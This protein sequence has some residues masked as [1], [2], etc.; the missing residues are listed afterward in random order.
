MVDLEAAGDLKEGMRLK[1]LDARLEMRPK[2]A[3]E[4][5]TQSSLVAEI[6]QK[7][8]A[9]P[10][11]ASLAIERLQREKMLVCR[12][13]AL[14]LTSG[15]R[16]LA[17][18]LKGA[19]SLSDPGRAKEV[20]DSLGLLGSGDFEACEGE[21]IIE[22]EAALALKEIRSLEAFD[23]PGDGFWDWR[24]EIPRV[25]PGPG[26]NGAAKPRLAPFSGGAPLPGRGPRP[27]GRRGHL[28]KTRR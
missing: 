12:G 18:G 22:R 23:W 21:A 27:A 17:E 9:S 13:G 28:A 26:E 25:R 1:A 5:F 10:K 16:R 19:L 4:L 15:G 24:R 7:G 14:S 6:C 11:E 8:L 2:S 20:R 3:L